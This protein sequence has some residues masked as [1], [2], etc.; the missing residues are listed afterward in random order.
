MSVT[1][2]L[3]RT[4][5]LLWTILQKFESLALMQYKLHELSLDTPE[6]R[7]LVGVLNSRV[8]SDE[9]LET[10]TLSVP[11][12]E[13]L[14]DAIGA[15]ESHTLIVQGLLLELLGQT[16]YQSFAQNS[17]VS[18]DTRA[19]CVL[20]LK[21]SQA[22]RTRLPELFAEKIGKGEDFFQAFITASRPVIKHLDGLGE[23]LDEHFS[24]RF[25]LHYTDL[26]GEFV[27]ELI[28][29]CIEL[30]MDRRK[31]MGSLTD[32]LMEN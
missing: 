5:L 32:A 10:T 28:S 4:E 2:E 24:M 23:G 25:G 30:G 21:A 15:D 20:G 26:I 27:A 6:K 8:P 13:L 17:S 22:N 1:V 18:P 9:A 3:D 31:L 14:A 19:L 7:T 29:A 11:V 12:T 16:I